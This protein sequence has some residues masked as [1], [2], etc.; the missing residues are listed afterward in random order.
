MLS[1]PGATALCRNADTAFQSYT[2]HMHLRCVRA[3]ATGLD[4][5][6]NCVSQSV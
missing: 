3:C 4:F 5:D 1:E 2:E 6:G